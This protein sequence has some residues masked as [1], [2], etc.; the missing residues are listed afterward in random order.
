MTT[1]TSPTRTRPTAGPRTLPLLSDRLLRETSA[2]GLDPRL[3]LLPT[4]AAVLLLGIGPDQP[5]VLQHLAHTV[6]PA[7]TVCSILTAAGQEHTYLTAH[8]DPLTRLA[9]GGDTA[10]TDRAVAAMLDVLAATDLSSLA[11]A[12][13]VAGDVLGP[14]HTQ[15][16]AP[17]DRKA[18][19]AFYTPPALAQ[20]LALMAGLPGPGESICDPCSGTGGL[21]IATVRA[22]RAAGRSA[23]L[24]HWHLQ[25]LDALALAIAGIQLSAHGLPWVTLTQGNSLLPQ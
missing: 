23:E 6:D 5:R 9:T 22:L 12:P 8:L 19:G 14:M 10:G 21:V 13:E 1:P 3:T 2:R 4:A 25:D 20:V 15:V 17:A 24:I 16:M 18:R 11:E 7:A